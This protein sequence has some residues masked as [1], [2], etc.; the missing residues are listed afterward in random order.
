MEKNEKCLLEQ[1]YDG[2]FFPA[3]Q[4]LSTDPDYRPTCKKVS[5]K[6][7]WLSSRM[8]DEEK[9]HLD[10][11]AELIAI[12]GSMDSYASFAYGFRYGALLMLEVLTGEDHPSCSA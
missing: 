6:M 2:E 3:E 12:R 10:E 9:K 11:L 1:L 7:K 4:I 5:E 8:G